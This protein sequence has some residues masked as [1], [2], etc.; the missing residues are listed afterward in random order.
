MP[1]CGDPGYRNDNDVIFDVFDFF[2]IQF[3]SPGSS[4]DLNVIISR[5]SFLILSVISEI[6]GYSL[7]NSSTPRENA[8]LYHQLV[9]SRRIQPAFHVTLIHRASRESDPTTWSHYTKQ[10]IDTLTAAVLLERT[11]PYVN[12]LASTMLIE[13]VLDDIHTLPTI[14]LVWT[15]VSLWGCLAWRLR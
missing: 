10:Y 5:L 12:T 1:P 14:M 4:H 7:F 9:N 2:E 8:R 3:H 15:L 11:F 13:V 6:S